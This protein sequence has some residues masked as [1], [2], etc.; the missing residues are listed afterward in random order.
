MPSRTAW[1]PEAFKSAS[2]AGTSDSRFRLMFRPCLIYYLLR[3]WVWSHLRGPS[4]R[5]R[6]KSRPELS[7]GKA[8][9]VLCKDTPAWG[10]SGLSQ[11]VVVFAFACIL[12]FPQHDAAGSF[13]GRGIVMSGGP[14]HVLQAWGKLYWSRALLAV[15]ACTSSLFNRAYIKQTTQRRRIGTFF[16]ALGR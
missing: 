8:S 2:H 1:P 15:S 16:P 11:H 12:H 3:A 10:Q 5:S 9:Y 4:A 7:A 6:A 13:A 14:M